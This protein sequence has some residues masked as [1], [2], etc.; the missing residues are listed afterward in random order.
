MDLAKR[1]G[2]LSSTHYNPTEYFQWIGD[3]E[4]ECSHRLGLA[5]TPKGVLS[6]VEHALREMRKVEPSSACK[7]THEMYWDVLLRYKGVLELG[8][9]TP[10]AQQKLLVMHQESFKGEHDAEVARLAPS[11]AKLLRNAKLT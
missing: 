7:P 8:H 6:I 1:L 10:Q 2:E 3:L 5:T 9:L 4:A 11:L